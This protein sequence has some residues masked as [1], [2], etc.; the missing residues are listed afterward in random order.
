[1]L[2]ILLLSGGKVIEI[3]MIT[4]RLQCII[5]HVT[6]D[7]IADIGTDHAYIP[8]KLIDDG[9]AKKVIATDIKEGPVEIARQNIKKYNDEDKIEVRLGGGLSVLNKNEADTII[10]AGMGGEMIETILRNN[11][12]TARASLLILQP[13][14]SQYEL[15]KYLLHNEY[16]IIDEDIAIE[17]FKVYNIIIVKSGS[18]KKFE[19]DIEYH[20]PKYLI[21][22]KY[23]KNLYDKKKREF[24]KVITGL[25]N[26]KET[27]INK[28]EKYKFWLK[29]L[30]KYESD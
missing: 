3:I 29:E 13:M 23:F 12:E 4:P 9:I 27:D 15:R 10:I 21:N 1:M 16:S 20:I 17:G 26:S 14:N 22:H 18:Q 11:E 7:I 5:N 25:E 6:G 8:I 2:N 30:E 24:I 19:Y 28:L